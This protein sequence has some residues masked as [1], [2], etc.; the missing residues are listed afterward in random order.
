MA[1][2]SSK[3]KMSNLIRME[4]KTN[5]MVWTHRASST[6]WISIRKTLP[7]LKGSILN[8]FFRI[9][10][11]IMSSAVSKMLTKFKKMEPKK[12]HLLKKMEPPLEKI[13][14]VWTR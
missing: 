2:P 13:Y 4:M 3:M 12:K 7:I 6:L 1:T 8:N 10:A 9:N 11:W 5:L 14:S